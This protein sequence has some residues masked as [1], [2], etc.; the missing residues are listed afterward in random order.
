MGHILISAAHKSSGK[1]MVTT[2]LVRA[3]T[4][5][6]RRVATFK[7]GPDYIDPKW[8][9]AAAGLT[10]G[11]S[12]YNLDF[13][14]QTDDEIKDMFARHSANADI[15]IIEGN[16]GLHDGVDV[17]GS[18]SNAA[19]AKMLG[20]PVILVIDASGIT[21]GI[22]PLLK[23]YEV[24][25]T[26]VNI[27]GVILNKVMGPRHEEKLIAAVERYTN[28]PV[29]GS[30]RR[31]AKLNVDERHIGLIPNNEYPAARTRIET[32]GEQIAA[33]VDLDR[34]EAIAASAAKMAPAQA[35][36]IASQT[37]RPDVRIAIAKDPA[38]GFYYADDLDALKAAGA[39]LVYFNTLNDVYLPTC[40][41]LFLGGGFPETQ[42]KRLEANKTLRT[43]IKA[44]IEAGLPTYA[45]CGGLM[46][47]SRSISWHED[48][49][50][51]VGV[52]P[53][54]TTMHIRPQGRGYVQLH[55]PPKHPWN[56]SEEACAFDGEYIPAHEFHHSRLEN[57]DTDLTF[58][59]EVLRGQGVNGTHD[60]IVMHN[61][62][63]GYTH[64]R[65][66]SRCRWAEAFT[67]F[68]RQK[69]QERRGNPS[70]AQ[71]AG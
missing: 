52:I 4:L 36:D 71:I 65:S 32:L 22:A 48:K 5:R 54:D 8:L 28:I 20:A 70:P 43:R 49:H 26:D 24:F 58:A 14:T 69:K 25:D 34:I 15:S 30:I 64:L 21:R 62:V 68:V 42:M 53:G 33:Q 7:K 39:Q 31:N 40:D 23:G 56:I 51:M 63:A 45:E 67:A 1:T 44:A 13:H 66:T 41:G 18:N 17:E 38:F 6:G 55:P 12:C 60:G 37:V 19:L 27:A 29:L 35:S 11:G 61:M 10:S 16:K 59:F 2:G 46:Y 47:L 57:I 3:L 9:A 50:E